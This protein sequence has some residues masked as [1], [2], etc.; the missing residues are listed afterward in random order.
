MN[1]KGTTFN[2]GYPK[3]CVVL[4]WCIEKMVKRISVGTTGLE[5]TLIIVAP[6]KSFTSYPIIMPIHTISPAYLCEN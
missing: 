3:K 5:S 6:F 1:A 4:S 2:Y